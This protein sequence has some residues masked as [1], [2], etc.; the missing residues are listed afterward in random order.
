MG[1]KRSNPLSHARGKQQKPENVWFRRTG[2]GYSLFLEY[3]ANQPIGTVAGRYDDILITKIPDM[4]INETNSGNTIE[5]LGRGL[6]RAAKRRK[7]KKGQSML[8]LEDVDQQQSSSIVEA[9]LLA[10]QT[11]LSP[12]L[13]DAFRHD[14]SKITACLLPFVHSMAMPLPLTLRVRQHDRMTSKKTELLLSA[15]EGIL[16]KVSFDESIYQ[17]KFSKESISRKCPELKDLLLEQSQNGS[18]ARQE[19][20]SMLPVLALQQVGALG[21][22]SRVLDLCS[23]PG[24]KTLQALEIVGTKGRVVANDVSETRLT[25]LRGAVGRSGLP[26]SYT[27]RIVYSCQ[28]ATQLILTTTRLWDAAMCDVPCSGDGTCRKDKHVL[29]MWKPSHGNELHQTQVKILLRALRWVKPGGVVCYSTCSLNPIEDEAVVAAALLH[30]RGDDKLAPAVEVIEWP[31][32]TGFTGRPGIANWKVADY[33]RDASDKGLAD[34]VGVGS[35]DDGE[36]PRLQWYETYSEAKDAGMQCALPSM[37]PPEKTTDLHLE[38]CTRLWP[39]DQDTG[40]FFLALL[41]KTAK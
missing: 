35:G 24:S 9:K 15:F 1:R 37:W 21:P 4:K 3:Y 16:D 2:A 31:H 36:T 25:A 17:A 38:R 39:Q 20:G 30:L 23:S 28:D 10:R 34:E 14:Q 40:G 22:N 33:P 29:P 19:I 11:P 12:Q 6:S 27:D 8:V 7:K 5:K 13:L 18:L 32:P 26:E 41:R